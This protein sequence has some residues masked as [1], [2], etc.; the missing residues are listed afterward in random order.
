MESCQRYPQAWLG[1][2]YLGIVGFSDDW[3]N[4]GNIDYGTLGDLR[5]NFL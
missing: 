1:L 2:V 5:M 4:L 3:Y